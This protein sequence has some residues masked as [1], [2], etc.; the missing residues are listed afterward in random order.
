MHIT[1]NG[2]LL[3][4]DAAWRSDNLL[5]W[6]RESLGLVGAKFGCGVGVCGACTVLLDGEAVRSCTVNLADVGS[7]SVTTIEGL[8]S[9]ERLH[10]VQQAWLDANVPQCGYCQ[11]GQIMSTVAL[12]RRLPKPDDTNINEALAGNLCRCGTHERIRQAVKRAAGLAS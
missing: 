2:R 11:S 7:R 10:P 1:I 3:P 8:A 12:L 6:L 5:H 9:G 4:V